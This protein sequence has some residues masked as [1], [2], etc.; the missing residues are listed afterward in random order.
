MDLSLLLNDS[1][2]EYLS[3]WFVSTNNHTRD[4]IGND[5]IIYEITNKAS[6]HRREDI[7]NWCWND[8]HPVAEHIGLM[9]NKPWNTALRH[10]NLHICTWWISKMCNPL[11]CIEDVI[12]HGCIDLL[13]I[14]K[15]SPSWFKNRDNFIYELR[16][17]N[18]VDVNACAVLQWWLE[19]LRALAVHT[20]SMVTAYNEYPLR[21][22]L[23]GVLHAAI[24]GR[25]DILRWCDDHADEIPF[26]TSGKNIIYAVSNVDVLNFLWDRRDRI[27]F[28][29]GNAIYVAMELGRV[30]ALKWFMDHDRERCYMPIRA[31][32][33]TLR[34]HIKFD[35]D[36][37]NSLSRAITNHCVDL[38]L[39][40]LRVWHDSSYGL[41]ISA[42]VI[43]NASNIGRIDILEWL[44]THHRSTF[45]Y[46]INAINL[47][48]QENRYNNSCEVLQW[49]YDKHKSF[50]IPFKFTKKA[51]IDASFRAQCNI[52]NWFKDHQFTM[53]FHLH[54]LPLF[55]LNLIKPKDR[56]LIDID[57]SPTNT[58]YSQRQINTMKFWHGINGYVMTG[59]MIKRC[60]R[61]SN[62]C[63]LDYLW[64]QHPVA[65]TYMPL[66]YTANGTNNYS[67]LKWLSDHIVYDI[68]YDNVI[69]EC[70]D[71][72][73]MQ[74]LCF[75]NSMGMPID[76]FIDYPNRFVLT[77]LWSMNFNVSY[78]VKNVLNPVDMCSIC[79]DE[80]GPM[81][82]VS[83]G[84]IYHAKCIN[85]WV[86]NERFTCP[87]CRAVFKF[88]IKSRK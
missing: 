58:D 88:R 70:V 45:T 69:E 22:D 19:E 87:Y 44:W 3:T 60:I 36:M 39:S 86:N 2:G 81:V 14:W 68:V 35:Q 63:I 66:I 23:N 49:W 51:Y 9:L 65:F 13:K 83:C 10:G 59:Q 67:V 64:E 46:T 61:Y 37:V 40:L 27:V 6:Q 30:K 25:V 41:K 38:K 8:C 43:D 48:A 47:L 84:H 62:L 73:F 53:R 21:H 79:M 82:S 74:S 26:I 75:W 34:I 18:C 76:M 71:K 78:L 5:P 1:S 11:Y 12:E 54:A 72:G 7:L 85:V 55:D 56:K 32:P 20:G 17:L 24:R 15:V 50:G 4:I 77:D 52:L 31:N 33:H 42:A 16:Q 57:Y 28:D 80:V 29:Y